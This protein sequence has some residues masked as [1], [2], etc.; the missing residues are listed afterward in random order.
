MAPPVYADLGKA[1]RD[2][3]GKGY[4]F[5][6]VKLEA[7]T[8]TQAGVNFT[9]SY[10]HNPSTARM[11]GS[12]ETKYKFKPYGLTVSEKWN[13][14]NSL[15]SDV[16]VEDMPCKGLKFTLD[17]CFG[18]ETD[19][20]TVN[21][22]SAYKHDLCSL[23]ADMHAF[24]EG[25]TLT[26]SAV[27]GH[28]GWL[29]GYQMALD[30]SHSRLTRSNLALGFDGG[31]F[32]L[33]ANI[34]DGRS[35]GASVHRRVANNVEAAV[36]LGWTTGTNVTNF[37]MGSKYCIDAD[38]TIRAK[39]NNKSEVALSL[40]QRIRKGVVLTLSTMIDAKNFNQGGHKLGLCL[41]LEA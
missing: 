27:V 12:L 31:D 29:A 6:Q 9:G 20:K 25:P 8:T 38:S 2:V 32:T 10:S 22:K 13:T 34:N 4:H 39:V 7:K 15:S 23:N 19:K 14:D 28:K 41:E 21:L 3:F 16:T 26:G 40:Q 35:F 36:D 1:A 17:S 24:P 33:H 30:I 11:Q 5:G 18:L 37:A